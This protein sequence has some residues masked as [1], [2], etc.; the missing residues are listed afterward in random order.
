MKR[1]TD[2]QD[3]QADVLSDI[4]LSVDPT[5]AL[6]DLH[7]PPRRVAQESTDDDTQQ[8]FVKADPSADPHLLHSQ[9][10]YIEW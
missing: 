3:R 10:A 2:R 4:R 9:D 1:R 8:N 7:D 6:G 5:L